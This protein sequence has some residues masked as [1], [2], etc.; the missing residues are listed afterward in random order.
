MHD[1]FHVHHAAAGVFHVVFAGG[2]GGQ[3]FAA[4]LGDFLP[5]RVFFA[6]QAEDLAA[7][8]FKFAP[9]FW[10]AGHKTGAAEGLV[11]PYPGVVVLVF[12]ESFEAVGLEA[13]VAVGAQAQVGLVEAARA[14][15]AG[16]PGGEAAGVFA[17]DV[18]GFGRAVVIQIHQIQIG[19]VGQ[20]FAAELAIADDGEAGDGAVGFGHG[21]PHL[22]HGVFEQDVGQ[23]GELIAQGFE[24]PAAGQIL[25]GQAEGLGVFEA[26]QHVHFGFGVAGG[27]EAT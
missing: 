6:R 9:H 27:L 14:G 24:R 26:A 10:A 5:Q 19:A 15:A 4:H 3:H 8:G 17:V 11:L 20:L 2:V 12:G 25:H 1:E 7:D 22:P 16:E 21:L 13:A 18:G 23:V